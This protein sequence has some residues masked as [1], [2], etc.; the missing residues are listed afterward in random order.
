MYRAVRS[1]SRRRTC[2]KENLRHR[3]DKGFIE[4]NM[5]V[6]VRERDNALGCVVPPSA[7]GEKLSQC[8]Q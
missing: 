4:T 6:W 2:G 3:S 7:V 1:P 8:S 5:R